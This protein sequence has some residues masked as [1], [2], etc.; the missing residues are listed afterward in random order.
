MSGAATGLGRLWT[1]LCDETHD[2]SA[3]ADRATDLVWYAAT[4]SE[5]EGDF[6]LLELKVEAAGMTVGEVVGGRPRLLVSIDRLDDAGGLV[7]TVL[8]FDG[9]LDDTGE[10][11]YG[12]ADLTLRYE[13]VRAD[14]LALQA[15]ALA[16][17]S[18]PIVDPCAGDT[19]QLHEALDAIPSLVHWSRTT[20]RPTLAS[21]V[22]GGGAARDLGTR[23]AQDSLRIVRKPPP[24]KRVDVTVSAEWTQ[25]LIGEFDVGAAI[26]AAA[27][28]GGLS[29]L[30]PDALAKDWPKVGSDLG[31][32]Y[33]V[34][35][36]SLEAAPAPDGAVAELVTHQPVAAGRGWRPGATVAREVRLPRTWLT[37]TLLAAAS[38]SVKRSETVTFSLH[39]G[40]QS[41]G[42]GVER[43][44]LRLDRL[45][46]DA[47]V[48]DWRAGTHYGQGAIVRFA[49]WL[50]QA[51]EPHDAGAS[52]WTDRW[53]R[54]DGGDWK[55]R[56]T[57]IAADASPL[58]G[59]GAAS[60]F[61]TAR[62]LLS[63]DHAILAAVSRLAYSQRSW[64]VTIV[65]DAF[66]VLDLS[67]RDTV[68]IVSDRIPCVGGEVVGKVKSYAFTFAADDAACEIVLAVSTGSGLPGVVGNGRPVSPYDGD[69]YR[70]SYGPPAYV[71][72]FA[73]PLG[74]AGVEIANDADYQA[75]VLFRAA[76]AGADLGAALGGAPTAIRVTTLPAGGGE[77]AVSIMVAPTAYQGFKGI[78]LR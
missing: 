18:L 7:D 57:I 76:D 40:G 33:L 37:P 62:G 30:T 72:P 68:R 16:G 32:G 17:L 63:L 64:E 55:Q 39:N 15:G 38:S 4:M 1:R 21:I 70:V 54:D 52:L 60:F 34:S 44:D 20:R 25:A 9:R 69:V 67:T 36:S 29:T 61:T 27:G 78:Q 12:D 71:V 45:A 2:W 6:P 51:A 19:R 56:W 14:W 22:G 74:I 49:G 48:P 75:D 28:E 66:D 24:L 43:I 26:T 31:G 11:A 59:P 77:A 73:P 58:G 50:W 23:W 3:E 46:F 8:L 13:A 41:V 5:S 42:T 35:V 65:V 53:F 10:V 47:A